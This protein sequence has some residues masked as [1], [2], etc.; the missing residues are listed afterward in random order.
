M[1]SEN[2]MSNFF[3]GAWSEMKKITWPTR[4]EAVKYTLTVIGICVVLAA[5][6]GLFDI[7][8]MYLIEKFVIF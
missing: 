6:L 2:K 7:L 1:K 3:G 5:F 8:Y 4:K